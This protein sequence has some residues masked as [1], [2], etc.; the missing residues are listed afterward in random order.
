MAGKE[1]NIDRHQ[2]WV[3]AGPA[4]E[5]WKAEGNRYTAAEVK[6]VESSLKVTLPR[7]TRRTPHHG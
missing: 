7:R 2:P 6:A 3:E 1:T 5:A 4:K